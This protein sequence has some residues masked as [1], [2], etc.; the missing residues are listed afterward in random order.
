MTPDLLLP[1]RRSFLGWTAALAGCALLT[2]PALAKVE[3]IVIRGFGGSMTETEDGLCMD[4]RQFT[5]N[6]DLRGIIREYR[7]AKARAEAAGRR[8]S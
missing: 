4:L 8:W 1:T 6:N 2:R 3:H 5:A 7:A